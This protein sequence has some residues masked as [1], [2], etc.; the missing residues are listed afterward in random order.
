VILES[1][2]S[3]II[4]I[5]MCRGARR[6]VRGLLLTPHNTITE[7]HTDGVMTTLARCVLRRTLVG[8]G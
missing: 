8:V 5:Y 4:G 3:Y 7:Q 2:A 6:V 1:I